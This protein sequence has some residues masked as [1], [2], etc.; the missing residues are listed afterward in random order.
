MLKTRSGRPASQNEYELLA[1][2]ACLQENGVKRYLEVGARHGDTFY[3]V[4]TALPAG[5]VGVA[6]DL[7]GALWGKAS[8]QSSLSDAVQ[9]LRRQGY[10]A[11]AIYGDSKTD[12]TKSLVRGRGPYDAVLIDG[13][14]TLAGVTADWMAY[15]DLA[16]I[17]AFHDIV[18]HDCFEKVY[19]NPVQVPLLWGSI[20]GAHRTREFVDTGS[21][22]GIGVVL[23]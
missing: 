2:I 23:K 19:R 7:P 15:G 16:P 8:S 21:R 11:S 20:R 17:V 6:V 5:A 18:G 10:D 1:F 13:D 3:A 9:E 22:M 4:M 12:A 14:H